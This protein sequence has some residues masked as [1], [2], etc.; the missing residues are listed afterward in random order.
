MVESLE[1][2][3]ASA[4]LTINCR[5]TKTLRLTRNANGL[6]QVVS[7]EAIDKFTYLCSEVEASSGTDLHIESRIKKA[8]S[9][10]GILSPFWGNT[11]LSTG[12]KLR[13]FKSNIVSVLLY[14]CWI[15]LH[16]PYLLYI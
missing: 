13:L 11:N 6:V 12:L 16:S 5:K 7:R 1:V 2:V 14:V 4:S 8:R 3:V 10:F 15:W 9:A